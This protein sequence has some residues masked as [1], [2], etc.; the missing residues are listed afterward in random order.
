MI[1]DIKLLWEQQ[2]HINK[3]NNIHLIVYQ[4]WFPQR[5]SKII[6]K[7]LKSIKTHKL[8]I[9]LMK[10]QKLDFK[11][12]IKIIHKIQEMNFYMTIQ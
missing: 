8:I 1:T 6:F 11:L 3:F 5:K 4:E 2:N 7:N 12:L 10:I 9:H